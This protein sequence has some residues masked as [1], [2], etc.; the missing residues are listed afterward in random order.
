M[1][2][3]TY[4]FVEQK[5]RFVEIEIEYCGNSVFFKALNELIIQDEND[6]TILI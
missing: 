1:A 3:I 6:K 5:L 2:V 4:I